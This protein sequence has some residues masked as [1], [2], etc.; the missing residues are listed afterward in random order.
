MMPRTRNAVILLA[1]LGAVIATL[2]VLDSSAFYVW[3]QKRMV[4]RVLA[5][6]P[7]E[8]RD[9]GR[10]FLVSRQEVV[11]SISLSSSDV[12]KTIRRLK[13]TFISVST[14]SLGVDF[15]DAANPFGLMIYAVGVNPPP[16]T[17]SGIGFRKWIDGVWLYDDGQLE[18]F[19]QIT[20]PN[21]GGPH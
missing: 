11:G 19:G 9:A 7:I 15:S 2:S 3:Q 8:L 17:K 21:A 16:K 12:P 14:N 13:P 6:N 10:T 5:A 1:I 20:G 18:N 4:R